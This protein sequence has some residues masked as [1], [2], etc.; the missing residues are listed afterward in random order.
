MK[1]ARDAVKD[2]TGKGGHGK[3][4]WWQ[5]LD[6][7][8]PLIEAIRPLRRCLVTSIVTKHLVFAWQPIDRVLSNALFVFAV[9]AGTAFAILQSRI[10][11][12]WARLLSSSMRNDLRY[13]ASDCF[14]TFPFPRLDPRTVIPPIEAVGERVYAERAKYTA[15]TNQGLTQTYNQLKDS[16]CNEPR[17][18]ALRKYHEDMDRAVLDAYGWTDLAVPPF[19]PKTPGEL[20]AVEEFQDAV[21]DRLFALNAER[22]S[23]EKRLG[24]GKPQK[25]RKPG[26]AK[27]R[28]GA[29]ASA[30]AP[31]AQSEL[32]FDSPPEEDR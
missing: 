1:P 16:R 9:D 2:D 31:H 11:E 6:R 27:A 7:C 12:P 15:D 8:D 5:F 30:K 4:Y 28:K 20:S 22:A 13:A 18:L 10:H 26:P 24:V 3:K 32:G 21:V 25:G 14:E 29:D 17:V 19:C 23:E